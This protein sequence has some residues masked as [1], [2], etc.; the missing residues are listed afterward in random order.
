MSIFG[1]KAASRRAQ[2][3]TCDHNKHHGCSHV[4]GPRTTLQ[5]V[6]CPIDM[7][8]NLALLQPPCIS[9]IVFCRLDLQRAQINGLIVVVEPTCSWTDVET[10]CAA[11]R[12]RC[13][14]CEL[15]AMLGK[16]QVHR[17]RRHASAGS[18]KFDPGMSSC[19]TCVGRCCGRPGLYYV[20]DKS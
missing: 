6:A 9:G 12:T 15:K 16:A 1:R 14:S 8:L 2:S 11:I 4:C 19:C 17:R 10:Y 3:H 18:R 7:T 13:S 20:L 5:F